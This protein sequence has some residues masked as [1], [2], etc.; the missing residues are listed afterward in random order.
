MENTAPVM[1]EGQSQTG[2]ETRGLLTCDLLQAGTA[3]SR[4]SVVASVNP[5]ATSHLFRFAGERGEG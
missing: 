3:L 2:G 5:H 4:E 1:A